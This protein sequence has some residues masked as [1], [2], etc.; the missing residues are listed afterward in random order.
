MKLGLIIGKWGLI[1]IIWIL[2][3]LTLNGGID[4][5]T[6]IQFSL[7]LLYTI[8]IVTVAFAVFNFAENPRAGMKFIISALSLGLIFLIGYNVSTDSFDQDGNLIEGSKLSEG[9]IYSLYVVTI[10][11]VLLI[12]ATEVKRALK[13]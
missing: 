9:G 3:L 7:G 10:I 12:A 1:L 6:L 2:I 4:S 13:L 8:T 11:A 5:M